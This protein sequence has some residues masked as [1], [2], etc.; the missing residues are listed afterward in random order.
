MR[1][2][3]APVGVPE[4]LAVLRGPAPRCLRIPDPTGLGLARLVFH[5]RAPRF[6]SFLAHWVHIDAARIAGSSQCVRPGF[7][8]IAR[9][10]QL[11]ITLGFRWLFVPSA[12]RGSGQ[13]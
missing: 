7:L 5:A 9:G 4:R 13:P 2:L 12:L 8:V 6:L 10:G 1:L 3:R 11:E